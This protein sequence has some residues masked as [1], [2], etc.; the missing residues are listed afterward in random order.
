MKARESMATLVH[1]PAPLRPQPRDALA[2][3]S[4]AVPATGSGPERLDAAIE[5]QGLGYD[6]RAI[7]IGYPNLQRAALAL[8]DRLSPDWPCRGDSQAS[9]AIQAVLCA[10]REVRRG[11]A[12]EENSRD[13]ITANFLQGL[14]GAAADTA[15]TVAWGFRGAT[16]VESF[17]LWSGSFEQWCRDR[18]LTEVRFYRGG[19]QSSCETEGTRLKLLCAVASARDVGTA[20]RW[21][22]S[23]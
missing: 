18:A 8:V 1:L 7:W 10:I 23:S 4:V 9:A 17:E 20:C 2:L 5:G 21:R 16:A 11:M 6:A 12:R 15:G 22:T 13:Q 3:H 19:G 14:A